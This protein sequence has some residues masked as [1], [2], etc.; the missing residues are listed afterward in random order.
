MDH[1]LS[2]PGRF[3]FSFQSTSTVARTELHIQID[4]LH[5]M[6]MTRTL[7]I[8]IAGSRDKYRPRSA[9]PPRRSV[10]G[11][12]DTASVVS[13]RV[14]DKIPRTH[15]PLPHRILVFARPAMPRNSSRIRFWPTI[16]D[17]ETSFAVVSRR[18][19]SETGRDAEVIADVDASPRIAEHNVSLLDGGGNGELIA[20]HPPTMRHPGRGGRHHPAYSPW[21]RLADPG[22]WATRQQKGLRGP[23]HGEWVSQR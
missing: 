6:A 17:P 20:D 12:D 18:L 23:S 4:R 3:S 21:R 15:L 14:T 2:D 1:C 22:C 10:R 5:P 7:Y 16:L 13:S 11:A 9:S 19:K 8:Q